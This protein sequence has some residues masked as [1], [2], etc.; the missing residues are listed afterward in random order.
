MKTLAL[1]LAA[2]SC[3]ATLF[4]QGLLTPPGAPAPAMKTLDQ[5]EPR[6]DIATLATGGGAQYQISQPG[7]YYLSS[8]LVISNTFG[9]SINSH[10][11]SLDLNGFKIQHAGG[12]FDMAIRANGSRI[13]IKNGSIS[14]FDEAIYA[15]GSDGIY[16]LRGCHFENLKI[17][18][19]QEYGLF[20]GANSTVVNCHFTEV[21]GPT[22]LFAAANSSFQNCTTD[23]SSG[24]YGFQ[25]GNGARV[26]NCSATDS[27]NDGFNAGSNSIFQ[28]CTATLNDGD[29][30]EL[31]AGSSV[32]SCTA[33]ENG[34]TGFDLGADSQ[35]S[36]CISTRNTAKGFF[37]S[38]VT[39]SGCTAIQ[40]GTIGIDANISS[41]SGC[42]A[43]YNGFA[44]I[45]TTSGSTISDSTASSN[46]DDGIFAGNDSQ[47]SDCMVQNNGNI[48]IYANSGVRIIKCLV[49][50]NQDEG[51]HVSNE[52]LIHVC[53]VSGNKKTGITTGSSCYIKDC[54]IG[55]NAGDGIATTNRCKISECMI[56]LNG[57]NGIT[58]STDC[59]VVDCSI[60]ENTLNGILLGGNNC[61]IKENYITRNGRIDQ[62]SGILS[63]QTVD[64]LVEENILIDNYN[65]IKFYGSGNL[66]RRNSATG[67]IG[68]NFSLYDNEDSA[69]IS[70]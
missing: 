61:Q 33:S 44:G 20:V 30:F 11:V 6:I 41:I 49:S 25:L 7:S 15:P 2:L 16:P 45:Y 67:N 1:S 36:D 48:G 55:G 17:S 29:G 58:L 43:S 52:C 62:K 46:G 8:N 54:V 32:T 59:T 69:N 28:A 63:L 26:F 38:D 24:G 70:Y 9:I 21:R 40:N 37:S 65:G 19:C 56:S 31:L 42:T 68:P 66:I 12:R 35:L 5:I 64:S 14:D 34:G 10:D 13:T 22:A 57:K 27:G 50:K 23:N 39:I 60:I 3:A 51:I 47:I 4:A 18:S 53:T